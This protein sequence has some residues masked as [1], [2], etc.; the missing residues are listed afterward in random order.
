LSY[1]DCVFNLGTS[2]RKN[3]VSFFL[4]GKLFRE[5]VYACLRD[6]LQNRELSLD[7]LK[8]VQATLA[9]WSDK[10]CIQEKTLFYW[11][12]LDIVTM[13]EGGF[14]KDSYDSDSSAAGFFFGHFIS[15]TYMYKLMKSS[16]DRLLEEKSVLRMF[17]ASRRASEKAGDL[18]L[19]LYSRPGSAETGGIFKRTAQWYLGSNHIIFSSILN[20]QARMN[21]LKAYTATCRYRK[22]NKALPRTWDDLAG[23]YLPEIPLDPYTEKPLAMKMRDTHL[24]FYSVGKDKNDNN[25]RGYFSR[26]GLEKEEIKKFSDGETDIVLTIRR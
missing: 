12:R 24:V 18:K 11:S 2:F 20:N 16:W 8:L 13:C 6:I 5:P 23:D 9:A 25:G 15:K 1:L 19:L 14:S 17:D 4:L 22:V 7:D 26:I 3:H 21:L 10:P